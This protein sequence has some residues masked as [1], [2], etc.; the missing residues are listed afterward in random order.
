LGTDALGWFLL[1]INGDRS[2]RTDECAIDASGAVVLHEDGKAIPLK[3]DLIGKC[4]AVLWTSCNAKLTAF[5]NLFGYYDFTTNHKDSPLSSVYWGKLSEPL[6]KKTIFDLHRQD[7]C[8]FAG[9][10]QCDRGE[11]SPI[12]VSA[13]IEIENLTK[14]L[15]RFR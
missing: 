11:D 2:I 15:S 6:W 4:K 8:Q 7:T 1:S 13:I 3:I 10:N 5:A 12:S 9:C 14:T